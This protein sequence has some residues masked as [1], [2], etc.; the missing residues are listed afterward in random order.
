MLFSR[1]FTASLAVILLIYGTTMVFF[2]HDREEY[3]ALV[4]GCA[5]AFNLLLSVLPP[6]QVK[7]DRYTVFQ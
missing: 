3:W 4:C 6:A 7:P 5:L 2:R 1:R